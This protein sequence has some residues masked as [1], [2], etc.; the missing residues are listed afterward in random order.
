MS[1][2]PQDEHSILAKIILDERGDLLFVGIPL[3][4]VHE[5]KV[6]L[7]VA[8]A[9]HTERASQRPCQETEAGESSDENHP[10]PQEQVD[11]LVEQIDGENALDGVALHVSKA[12][13]LEVAHGHTREAW[14]RGPVFSVGERPHHVNSIQMEIGSKKSVKSEKLSDDVGDE[15]Q[16]AEEVEHRKVVSIAT[17][18]D[19]AART[20]DEM[21]ETD[22]APCAVLTLARQVPVHLLCHVF[23]GFFSAL[24]KFRALEC[25]S[26]LHNVVDVD[27]GAAIKR[28]PDHN[29]HVEKKSLN[30]KDHRH[31][32]VVWD[33]QPLLVFMLFRNVL[34]EGKVVCISDPAVIVGVLF[35]ISREMGRYPAVNGVAHILLCADNYGENHTYGSGETMVETV[36]KIIIIS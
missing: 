11:F 18:A 25:L 7:D 15:D 16:L 36:G 2:E 19:Q 3:D 32:L 28:T 4:L 29:R 1:D 6:L 31:P 5:T 26:G 13:H 10:E 30:Q 24:G 27:S 21:L 33:H 9:I 35:M 17:T 22:R 12:T 14:R 34:L 20:G 8:M 23:Q